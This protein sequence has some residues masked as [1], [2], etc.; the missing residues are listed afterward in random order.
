MV[1]SDLGVIGNSLDVGFMPD[2]IENRQLSANNVDN[3]TGSASHIICDELAVGTGIGQ[4]LLFV[5]GLHKTKRLL[6]R[7]AVIAVCF[8]L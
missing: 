3:R 1:V 5:E 4:E 8:T 7:E 6:C 2:A